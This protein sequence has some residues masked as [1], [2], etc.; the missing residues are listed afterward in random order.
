MRVGSEGGWKW[1]LLTVITSWKRSPGSLSLELISLM[2]FLMSYVKNGIAVSMEGEGGG[3]EGDSLVVLEIAHS[4]LP[5]MFVLTLQWLHTTLS[6]TTAHYGTCT[7]GSVL[8]CGQIFMELQ[9][10]RELSLH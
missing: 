5:L 1:L 8:A 7:S 4:P 10:L 6:L 3:G 2:S 9:N